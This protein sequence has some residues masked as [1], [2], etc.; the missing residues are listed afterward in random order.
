MHQEI[1]GV[2]PLTFSMYQ[3][4]ITRKNLYKRFLYDWI[5]SELKSKDNTIR[6]KMTDLI[7]LEFDYL[8][9]K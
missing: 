7:D 9:K 4:A 5:K 2:F 6:Q 8:V 1:Q 3:R